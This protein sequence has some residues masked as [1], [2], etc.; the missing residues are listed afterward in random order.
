MKGH[1]SIPPSPPF[2]KVLTTDHLWIKHDTGRSSANRQTDQ[3]VPIAGPFRLHDAQ[4]VGLLLGMT[5]VPR[6]LFKPPQAK[7]YGPCVFHLS[8]GITGVHTCRKHHRFHGQSGK[9]QAVQTT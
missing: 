9:P 5:P 8:R 1:S 2:F 3:V 7:I 4:S 6:E